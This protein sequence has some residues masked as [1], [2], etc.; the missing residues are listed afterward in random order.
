MNEEE[1]GLGTPHIASTFTQF[2]MKSVEV[3]EDVM[4]GAYDMQKLNDIPSFSVGITQDDLCPQNA[5]TEKISVIRKEAEV[6]EGEGKGKRK[7]NISKYGQSP[8]L[9]RSVN[10]DTWLDKN[11]KILWRNLSSCASD[12]EDV[13]LYL[14]IS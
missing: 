14:E 9:N 13:Y 6:K 11:D 5:V 12:T 1:D 3:M 10:M 2:V 4:A 8:F 7:K